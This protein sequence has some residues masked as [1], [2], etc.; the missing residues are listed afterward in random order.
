VDA[1]GKY[2]VRERQQVG[3]ERD[4][5][6]EVTSRAIRRMNIQSSVL[7]AHSMG[8]IGVTRMMVLAALRRERMSRH[9]L[10]RID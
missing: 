7:M 1:C 3:V 5:T 10:G 4:G 8:I 6:R 9:G 2:L